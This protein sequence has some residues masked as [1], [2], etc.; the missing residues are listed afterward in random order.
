[1]EIL[2]LHYAETIRNWFSN[3][4]NNREELRRIYDEKFCRMF[5][6]YLAMSEM[7]FRYRG[8][9]VFQLQLAKRFDAAPF[10]RDYIGHAER[11]AS[12]RPKDGAA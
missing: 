1:M 7:G 8:L 2:R 6:Y 10:T 5:E 9:M 12:R 3:F 11:A 4:Q